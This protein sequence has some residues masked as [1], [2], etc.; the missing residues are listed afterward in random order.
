MM[1][2]VRCLHEMRAE[3]EQMGYDQI[4]ES[5]LTSSG[6][7]DVNQPMHIVPRGAKEND[8]TY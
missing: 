2:W 8:A 1:T 5:E 4:P 6:M 7:I 3:L